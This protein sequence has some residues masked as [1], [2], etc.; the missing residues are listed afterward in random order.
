M[1]FHKGFSLLELLVVVTILVILTGVLLPSLIKGRMK[2]YQTVCAA[3][4][5]EVL[6]AFEFYCSDYKGVYPCANDGQVPWLWMG[7]GWR[8]FV[9]PYL[10]ED[11]SSETPG[12]L[13][14][15]AEKT[16]KYDRTSYGYSMSFY[17]SSEQINQMKDKSY[18]YSNPTIGIGIHR[19]QVLYP[20]KKIMVGEWFSNHQP[21]TGNYKT[22]PGWWSWDGV[23]NFIFPDGHVEFLP[24]KE[25]RAA[26]DNWPDPNLTINGIEGMDK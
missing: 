16:D 22:E 19:E 12:I 13:Q 14:C 4:L 11:I 7:R 26:N 15:P 23:R 5:R 25:I 20:S 17:H 10:H 6:M 21:V 2:A 24:A 18:T 8:E 9:K 1:F 3:N